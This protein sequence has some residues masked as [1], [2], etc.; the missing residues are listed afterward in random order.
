MI[1]YA[2]TWEK[3]TFDWNAF[4]ENPPEKRSEEHKLA[5]YLSGNW[6]TCACGVQ[7]SSIPRNPEGMPYDCI[8][9]Y[10]GVKFD[11]KI[12]N[13]FWEEAKETLDKIEKR[14]AEII[15]ELTK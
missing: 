9:K 6:V 8:S 11:L 12:R 10:L 7:C 13:C 4:L 2:E 1:T 5:I 14:S 15:F 3:K